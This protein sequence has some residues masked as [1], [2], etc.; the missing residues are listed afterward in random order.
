MP[1]ILLLA[2]LYA[3]LMFIFQRLVFTK[4][5]HKLI[6]FLPSLFVGIV[7][8]SAIALPIVDRIQLASG[9]NDGHLFFTF[10]ALIVAGINTAGLA[11]IGAAWLY[12]RV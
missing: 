7:Y 8:L 1:K 4:S 11:G 6:H 10:V 3:A 12:E 5:E 2:F 9:Q